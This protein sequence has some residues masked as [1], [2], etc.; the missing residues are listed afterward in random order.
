MLDIIR[1]PIAKKRLQQLTRDERTFLLLLG[2]TANQITVLWKLII[3]S[4]NRTP[5]D[6]VE[7]RVT[8]AQTQIFVRQ[9][10]GVLWEAWILVE[11]RFI[12]SKLGRDYTPLLAETGQKAL[13]ELKKRFGSSNILSVLRNNYSF[14]HP[15]EE[16]MD[17]AFEAAVRS[18][19]SEEADWNWYLTTKN[20]NTFYFVSDFIIAHGMMNAIGETDLIVAHQKIMKELLPVADSLSV[21]AGAFTVAILDKYFDDLEGEICTTIANAPNDSSVVLPFYIE[22]SPRSDGLDAQTAR[23]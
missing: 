1:I 8:G 11:R 13:T 3:F 2:Y 10:I 17:A 21:F 16:D 23:N 19:H 6:P 5:D 7:Q 9:L 18:T 12:G 4:T 14:H 22:I 20:L 15:N